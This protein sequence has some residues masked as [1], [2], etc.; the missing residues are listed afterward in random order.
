MS[1]HEVLLAKCE[2]CS[3]ENLHIK[4]VFKQLYGKFRLLLASS[5]FSHE[6]TGSI[7]DIDGFTQLLRVLIVTK[8]L[9]NKHNAPCKHLRIFKFL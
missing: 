4:S 8:D 2:V 5:H 1:I 6:P 7:S 3:G 9:K